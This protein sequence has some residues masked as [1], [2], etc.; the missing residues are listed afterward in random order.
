MGRTVTLELPEQVAARVEAAAAFSNRKVEDVVVDWLGQLADDRPV[1]ALT[2]AE[3]LAVADSQMPPTEADQLSEL[4]T[5]Q[6]EGRLT[7]DGRD[8]LN[9]LMDIYYQGQLRK[10]RGLAEA[11]RRGLI[12]RGPYGRA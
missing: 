2:D 5:D 1:E 3:V 11:V 4:Q 6:R 8:R 7:P 10:A 12:P 9:R